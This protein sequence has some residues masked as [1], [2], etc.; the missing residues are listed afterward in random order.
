M[1]R[2]I[3]IAAL[4][5]VGFVCGGAFASEEEFVALH[6]VS[7]SG[8]AGKPFGEVHATIETT[9]DRQDRRIKSIT[10]TVNGKEVAVPKEQFSD[11]KHPLLRTAEFRTEGGRDNQGPWLYLTFQLAKPE[12]GSLSRVYLRFR[13]GKLLER[14]IHD[15]Q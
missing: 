1:T 7:L 12:T 15:S 3:R 2:L 6:K 14:S 8:D 4:V 10:L 5:F 9:K 13:N 11:L